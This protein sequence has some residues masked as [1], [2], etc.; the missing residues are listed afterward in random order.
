VQFVYDPKG[1]LLKVID[2]RGTVVLSCTYNSRGERTSI[3]DAF[4]HTYHYEFDLYGNVVEERDPYDKKTLRTY[5]IVDR[6]TSTTNAKGKTTSFTYGV[7]DE[8]VKIAYPDQTKTRFVWYPCCQILKSVVD[9]KLN[10]TTYFYDEKRRLI[11]VVDAA[12]G[13]IN[14]EYDK[15]DNRTAIIDPKTN[16]TELSYDKSNRLSRIDYPDGT[17]ESFTYYPDG[18]LKTKT[19]GN[20]ATISFE[21][22]PVGKLIKKCYPDGSH[23]DLSHDAVGNRTSMTDSTGTYTYSRDDLYRLTGVTLPSG[24]SIGY[25]YD[26]QGL[27][28]EM[29]DYDHKKYVYKYDKMNRLQSLILPG[30]EKIGYEYDVLSNLTKVSYPNNTYSAYAFNDMNR[31]TKISTMKKGFR[32]KLI[33]EF[34]YSYDEVGNRVSMEE[35]Q[36]FG[37]PLETLYSFDSLYRLATVSYPN[38]VDEAYTYDLSGNRTLCET[39][40]MKYVSCFVGWKWDEKA[41]KKFVHYIFHPEYVTYIVKYQYDKANKLMELKEAKKIHD[42]EL[43]EKTVA[44]EFD[45]NGNQ[46]KESILNEGCRKPV[47]NDFGYDYENH[48]TSAVMKGIKQY[49]FSYDGE[50]KRIKTTVGSVGR[51]GHQALSRCGHPGESA[52][53]TQHLYD[54]SSMIM[55]LDSKGKVVSS[56]SYGIGLNAINSQALKGYYHSDAL[57]SITEITGKEGQAIRSYRY[58]AWGSFTTGENS[59]DS[60]PFRYVGAYGVRWQ[61]STLGLYHM[62]ARFYK[63][64]TGRFNSPDP[65]RTLNPYNYC[66]DNPIRYI[67]PSGYDAIG[68]AAAAGAAAGAEAVIRVGWDYEGRNE[69]NIQYGLQDFKYSSDTGGLQITIRVSTDSSAPTIIA[70]IKLKAQIIFPMYIIATPSGEKFTNTAIIKPN[71]SANLTDAT[72]FDI[73]RLQKVREKTDYSWSATTYLTIT[74]PGGIKKTNAYRCWGTVTMPGRW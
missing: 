66:Q 2:P 11:K 30:N 48:L 57:G 70:S 26:I 28:A 10:G 31:L 21:Y 46:V 47:V 25:S 61:D 6:L 69:G 7:K 20:G 23:Q 73:N 53:V 50:G 4:G 35:R 45:R 43:L 18:L 13:Q 8:L 59:H 5:D 51:G 15:N 40:K 68:D 71:G 49:G 54:G 72:D 44:Y 37:K 42:K 9:A 67:D 56:Y 58:D 38:H 34:A 63:P 52:Q 55:D 41:C 22:D 27:R 29:T 39:K 60:N 24:K 74:G 65:L 3:S 16:R 32:E 1:N 33:S 36:I 64:R 12:N 17:S 14:L 19:D 62:Q